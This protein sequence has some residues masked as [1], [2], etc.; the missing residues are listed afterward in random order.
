M[1]QIAAG[2]GEGCRPAAFIRRVGP[3]SK[4]GT[5]TPLREFEETPPAGCG[6]IGVSGGIASTEHEKDSQ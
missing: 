3:E 2:R 6:T 4:G 1:E 5:T